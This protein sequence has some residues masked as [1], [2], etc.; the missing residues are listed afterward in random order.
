M[1]TESQ[2]SFLANAAV[3]ARSAG[4]IFPD[5]AACEAALESTWGTSELSVKGHNL[6]GQKQAIHPSIPG[7]IHIPTKEFIDHAWKT[8]DAAW[9]VFESEQQCFA[10]RM[11]TLRRLAPTYPHYAIALAAKDAVTYVSEVSLSWST[12]PDRAKKCVSIYRSHQ[13][14]LRA[15]LK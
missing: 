14:I 5:M 9:V 10:S 8:V 7:T 15:A 4:H 2:Q 13:D 6:F 12:D 3:A 1:L 11:D